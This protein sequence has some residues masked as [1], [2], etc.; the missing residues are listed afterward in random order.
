MRRLVAWLPILGRFGRKSP[1]PRQYVAPAIPHL[2]ARKWLIMC[3][4]RHRCSRER[5]LALYMI[6]SQQTN[7][8][9]WAAHIGRAK[10]TVPGSSPGQALG[11]VHRYNRAGPRRGHLPSQRRPTP[12]F[13]QDQL[14]R[15][16]HDGAYDFS[17]GQCFIW[18]EGS[19]NQAHTTAFLRHVAAWIGDEPGEAVLIWDGAPWHKAKG[20]QAAASGLGF[21]VVALPSYRPDLN[22]IEEPALSLTEGLWKWMREEVRRNFCH[23][24]R[25]HLFD[26]CKAFIDRIN[27]DPGRLSRGC[28]RDSNSTRSSGNSWYQSRIHFK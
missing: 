9:I 18:N 23:A 20:V 21:T 25:R 10:E 19:C 11:W 13:D 17:R 26:A 22:P 14:D 1:Q 15:L 2:P 28:G 7:A 3:L 6:A 8:T 4:P 12:P 5:L 27:A 16:L 24:S